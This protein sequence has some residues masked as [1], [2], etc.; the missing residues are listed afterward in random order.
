MTK[1]ICNE[2]WYVVCD[3]FQTECLT[4]D[5]YAFKMIA[6]KLSYWTLKKSQLIRLKM[7][8]IFRL[9]RNDARGISMFF[10]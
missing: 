7:L 1:V 10:I 2:K 4:I 9:V 8:L 3:V 6:Q 5:F